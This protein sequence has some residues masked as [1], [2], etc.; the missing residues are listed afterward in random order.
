MTPRERR[1]AILLGIEAA[2][3][4]HDELGLRKLVEADASCIDVFGAIQELDVGLM[5]RPL[6]GLL[7]VSLPDPAPGGILVSTQRELYVQRFTAAHE[8]GHL[9][10]KHSGTL[11]RKVDE[12]GRFSAASDPRE[13][14]AD[15]FAAEFLTPKWLVLFHAR[16]QGWTKQHLEEPVL[17]YQLALRLGVSYHATCC[18]LNAHNLLAPE[19][20]SRLQKVPPKESKRR[21]LRG[22]AV[23]N[24]WSDV[25]LLSDCDVESQLLGG[26]EDTVVVRL[27]EHAGAGYIWDT[28]AVVDAGFQILRDDRALL[29]TPD[30]IGGAVMRDIVLRSTQPGRR[31]L[32]FDE[33]RP[34]LPPGQVLQ[35]FEVTLSL[36]G[37][38]Q[39]G[40]PR[41]TREALLSAPEHQPN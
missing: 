29:G 19:V 26:P 18:C 17:V 39:T 24:S 1:E 9:R 6:N 14:A 41:S 27:R 5:F 37:K 4:L 3:T 25:W 31:I 7:G 20:V 2:A 40:L 12:S 35:H 11:D 23:D 33:R 22:L 30:T 8:L 32:Q 10:L 16:R 21:L 34:W 36:Y 28:S 38:E 13:I 15:A